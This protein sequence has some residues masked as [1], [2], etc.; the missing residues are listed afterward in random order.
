MA[1]LRFRAIDLLGHLLFCLP[2]GG[3]SALNWRFFLISQGSGQQLG[4]VFPEH[5]DRLAANLRDPGLAH[6]EDSGDL[7]ERDV[8]IIVHR[9][10]LLL[11]LRELRYALSQQ[12]DDRSE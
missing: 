9:Q 8:F 10:D 11:E 6:P 7:R 2:T 3:A 12:R 4:E 1:Y 5:D